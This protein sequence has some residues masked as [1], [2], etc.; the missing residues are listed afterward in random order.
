MTHVR[1]DLEA[2]QGYAN[3]VVAADRYFDLND[4]GEVVILQVE[5]DEADRSRVD[6]A[7]SSCPVNA[8][9]LVDE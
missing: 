3:C 9:T 2:C 5:V 6:M 7:V 1:A 8:L 4:D